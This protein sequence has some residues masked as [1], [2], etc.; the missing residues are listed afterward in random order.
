MLVGRQLPV[1]A[2]FPRVVRRPF[3]QGLEFVRSQELEEWVHFNS[4]IAR[5]S[6]KDKVFVRVHLLATILPPT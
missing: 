3:A 1:N 2:S 6:W 5:F 4:A